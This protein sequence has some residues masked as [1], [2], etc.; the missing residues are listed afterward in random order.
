M[1]QCFSYSIETSNL[2]AVSGEIPTTVVAPMGTNNA[3]LF[4]AMLYGV[5]AGYFMIVSMVVMASAVTV[6]LFV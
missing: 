4:L 1:Q 6:S 3:I 5:D 2:V